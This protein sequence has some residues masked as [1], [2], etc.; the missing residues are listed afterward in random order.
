[1]EGVGFPMIWAGYYR[2]EGEIGLY[3]TLYTEELFFFE[4]GDAIEETRPALLAAAD[5]LIGAD[6][7]DVEA[8]LNESI[9]E[10]TFATRWWVVS[11]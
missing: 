6:A 5:L 10:D 3:V 2:H 7:A 8:Y 9:D 1:M 11:D 4:D